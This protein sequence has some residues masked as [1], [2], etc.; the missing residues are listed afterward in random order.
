MSACYWRTHVA[1]PAALCSPTTPPPSTSLHGILTRHDSRWHGPN[2]LHAQCRPVLTF[3][4]HTNLNHVWTPRPPSPSIPDFFF[5]Q[6]GACLCSL[7]VVGDALRIRSCSD[8]FFSGERWDFRKRNGVYVALWVGGGGRCGGCTVG[9]EGVEG[10]ER[11]IVAL[12]APDWGTQC[13]PMSNGGVSVVRALKGPS[14]THPNLNA[15]N[16]L[17]RCVWEGPLARNLK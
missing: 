9:G 10:V 7:C 13:V 4:C 3:S 17:R 12:G 16:T 8:C 1:L 14:H 2:L 5:S 11:G 6:R 15:A